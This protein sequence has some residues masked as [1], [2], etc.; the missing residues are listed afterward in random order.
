MKLTEFVRAAGLALIFLGYGGGA[1]A[2]YMQA[3]P[4][5]LGGGINPYGYVDADPLSYVDAE[6][7]MGNGASS[8]PSNATTGRTGPYKQREPITECMKAWIL[9]HYGPKGLYVITEASLFSLVPDSGN[10]MEGGP[11]HGVL[12]TVGWGG[13]KVGGVKV[14]AKTGEII[15]WAAADAASAALG[16][17]VTGGTA[18]FVKFAGRVGPVLVLSATAINEMAKQECECKK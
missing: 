5:G 13:A 17:T 18:G 14:A 4:I 9:D 11:L 16:R 3:D 10:L 7:L 2:R 12:A 1:S 8:R 15:S 6:G